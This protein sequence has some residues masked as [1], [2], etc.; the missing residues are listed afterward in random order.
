MGEDPRNFS[1]QEKTKAV[2]RTLKLRMV[3]GEKRN[4]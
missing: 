2:N 4:C 1:T 3:E